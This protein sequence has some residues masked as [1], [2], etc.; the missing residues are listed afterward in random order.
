MKFENPILLAS[1]IAGVTVKTLTRA[2]ES[3]AGGVVSKSIGLEP[4]EGYRN[5]T[6]VATDS[7][8]LNAVGL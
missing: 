1:G 2:I 4:R 5:P 6:L 3:G 8:L 7:G